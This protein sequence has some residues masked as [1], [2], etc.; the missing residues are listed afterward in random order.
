MAN[1]K[2]CPACEGKAK[3]VYFMPYNAVKCTKC[4]AF[5]KI[6]VDSYEQQDGKAAAIEAWN[7]GLMMDW[8]QNDKGVYANEAD[9]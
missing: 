6:I 7:S 4:K 5:G 9:L 2:R 1:L 3:Y 8:Q